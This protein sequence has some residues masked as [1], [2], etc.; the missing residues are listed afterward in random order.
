M[1]G[2]GVCSYYDRH[3][4]IGLLFPNWEQCRTDDYGDGLLKKSLL[5]FLDDFL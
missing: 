2:G 3:V 4:I 5:N 1:Y